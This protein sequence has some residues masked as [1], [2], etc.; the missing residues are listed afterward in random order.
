MR[1]KVRMPTDAEEAAIQRGIAQDPDN[2]EWTA[3][4]FAR[5]QPA[6]EALPAEVYA[7]LVRRRGKGVKPAKVTV[8]LRLDPHV[9]EALRASGPGWHGRAGAA[10]AKLAGVEV[11]GC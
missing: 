1:A 3:A 5:A 10:L 2:P 7:G 11:E 8:A 6:A 9:V 4:D